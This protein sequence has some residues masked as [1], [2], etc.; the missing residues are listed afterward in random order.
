MGLYYAAVGRE[1]GRGRLFWA[2]LVLLGLG[3]ALL[4]LIWPGLLTA[5]LYGAQPGLAVLVVV[6]AVQWLLHERYRRRIV[7]LPG[8]RRVKSGSSMVRKGRA[9]SG[10]LAG[11]GRGES[12]DRAA[13]GATNQR[14]S[15]GARARSEPSTV[16]APPPAG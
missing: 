13:G 8:F 5:L 6:L 2:L 10:S 7:F 9:E 15:S 14:S 3:V 11:A 16:D 4:G 12:E 1:R